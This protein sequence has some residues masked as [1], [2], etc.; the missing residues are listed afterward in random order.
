[1]REEGGAQEPETPF[2]LSTELQRPSHTECL[3]DCFLS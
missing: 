1:M 2:A 3:G